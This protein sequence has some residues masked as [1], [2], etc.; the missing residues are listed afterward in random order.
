MAI[1]PVGAIVSRQ[2][3]C[4]PIEWIEIRMSKPKPRRNKRRHPEPATFPV[5]GVIPGWTQALQLMPVGSKWKLC[6][7][8]DLAYGDN[9]AGGRIGPNA[10]LVFEGELLSIEKAVE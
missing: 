9:G 2:K 10:T 4:S 3:H 8:S 5:G 1:S 7:P 6:I